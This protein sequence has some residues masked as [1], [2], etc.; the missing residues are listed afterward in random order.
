MLSR[1]EAETRKSGF[2][3]VEL[4]VTMT[5][6]GT[7]SAFTFPFIIGAIRQYFGLQ[8]NATS[9]NDLANHYQRMANVLRG[10]TGINSAT[11]SDLNIYAYFSPN[12]SYVSLVHYYLLNGKLL[13][14]VTPMTANPPNGTP[15]TASQKT[16]TIIN[17]FVSVPGVNLFVY[18]DGSNTVLTPPI[19][20][21]NTIKAIQVN[22]AEPSLAPSATNQ[23]LQLQVSLRNR[24]TNL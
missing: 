23:A 12:D 20:D 18:F 5:L 16:Y 22:L 4:L 11:S 7:V 3:I 24:K 8:Q 15:I 19:S 6:I 10:I 13:A 14:D 1:D 21:L 2:T 17:Q 9:F